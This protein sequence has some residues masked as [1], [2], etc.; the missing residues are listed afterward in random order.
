MSR[1][2]AATKTAPPPLEKP[3]RGRPPKLLAATAAADVATFHSPEAA[4]TIGREQ[5]RMVDEYGELDRRIQLL[6][7]D[8]ARHDVLKR[9]IKSWFDGLPADADGFVEGTIYRL[10]LSARERERRIRSLRE[11]IAAIGLD[12]FLEIANVAIGPVEDLLGKTR[13]ARLIS[14][15][16]TGSRRIKAVPKR[17]ASPKAAQ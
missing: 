2:A 11:L 14:E 10:H 9:A 13:T 6:A 16:R 4:V 1:P 8:M 17:P 12:K 7:P 3:R 5:R 15:A